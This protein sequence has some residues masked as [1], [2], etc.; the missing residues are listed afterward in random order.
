MTK[1][2][3]KFKPE[4]AERFALE[5]GI[6]TELH[7]N[8]LQFKFCPY[9]KQREGYFAI[10]LQTGAF[11]CKRASC[12]AKGNML[13]LHRDFGFDLGTGVREYERPSFTWRRF[14]TKQ[15]VPTDPAIA[16]LESRGIPAEVTKS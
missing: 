12:G 3:Y 4:D 11:N 6:R 7:G 16:Y 2:L 14:K 1:S 9:C 15:I 5:Q 10:N 8:E 13:T